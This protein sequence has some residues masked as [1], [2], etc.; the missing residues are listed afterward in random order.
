MRTGGEDWWWV[1]KVWGK[2][3]LHLCGVENR[4]QYWGGVLFSLPWIRFEHFVS[5]FPPPPQP[6]IIL[7]CHHCSPRTMKACL[8]FLEGGGQRGGWR[9]L[10]RWGWIIILQDEILEERN[11]IC[12]QIINKLLAHKTS[13]QATEQTL[14]YRRGQRAA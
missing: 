11:F 4:S 14:S 2:A 13:C 6:D 3:S 5:P 12:T 10:G 1:G 8:T 7:S 9:N